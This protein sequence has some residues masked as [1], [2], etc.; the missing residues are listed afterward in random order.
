MDLALTLL[1]VAFA[2]A[3]VLRKAWRLVRT[4]GQSGCG[5]GCGS[6]PSNAARGPETPLVSIDLS[7]KRSR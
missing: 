6:C 3:I 7:P 1:I 5:T 2:A 4:S